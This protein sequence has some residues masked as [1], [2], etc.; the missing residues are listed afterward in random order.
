MVI[1]TPNP[2]RCGS[3][4]GAGKAVVF[5][6]GSF[7]NV[8]CAHISSGGTGNCEGHT[9][10]GGGGCPQLRPWITLPSL[11]T[12]VPPPLPLLTRSTLHPP[13]SFLLPPTQKCTPNTTSFLKTLLR[14]PLP[15]LY[16][17][18]PSLPPSTPSFSAGTVTLHTP[19]CPS[20]LLLCRMSPG[21]AYGTSIKRVSTWSISYI[22]LSKAQGEG[23]EAIQKETQQNI[24]FLLCFI[25]KKMKQ[26]KVVNTAFEGS[27]QQRLTFH[28]QEWG[29]VK[30]ILKRSWIDVEV[31]F[32]RLNWGDWRFTGL[33][34]WII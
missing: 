11:S 32:N 23:S 1:R 20:R 16:P 29:V 21:S 22:N 26:T 30:V 27:Q 10:E 24:T 33:S 5:S 7:P 6:F 13:P 14:S 17:S 3:V 9:D 28:R 31:F 8:A 2:S 25:D 4:C 34:L 19:S 18:P 15:P 12:R